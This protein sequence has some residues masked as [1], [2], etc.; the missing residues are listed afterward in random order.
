MKDFLN[1]ASKIRFCFV[2]VPRQHSISSCLF[3]TMKL[4]A[5]GEDVSVWKSR[6]QF[7]LRR[8][9]SVLW[10][11]DCSVFSSPLSSSA[12]SYLP[13]PGMVPGA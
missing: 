11:S 8:G 3:L 2:N 5:A 12:V 4:K 6:R 7:C 13:G 10:M 1:M 9:L